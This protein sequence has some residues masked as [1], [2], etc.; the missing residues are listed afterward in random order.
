MS[1]S[2]WYRRFTVSGPDQS[3][4]WLILLVL[5]PLGLLYGVVGRLRV[6]AYRMGWLKSVSLSVPVVSVGNLVAGGTG[7]TPMVDYLLGW[8]RS[9]NIRAAV[10]SRGY[11]GKSES[12]LL[13]VCA[14]DGLLSN[15]ET[16]GDEPCLLAR[17]NPDSIII[18]GSDRG[19]A[20]QEA[21]DHHHAQ[22]LILDDGFQHLRLKRDLNLLLADARRP[23]GN[24]RV[25]PAGYL[26]EFPQAIDRAD[27]LIMTRATGV[28]GMAPPFAG[29]VLKS[30]HR[31]ATTL[32][33]QHGEKIP[34][35]KIRGKKGIAFCGI[36]DPE[37]FFEQIREL[38]VDLVMTY[39]FPDH[40]S[41]PADFTGR[42]SH[43]IGMADFFLTTEKDGVKLGQ[44]TMPL[45][46]YQLS[47]NINFFDGEQVLSTA[48][49]HLINKDKDS[50]P[51]SKDLLEIL[52]CPQ[53]KGE[54]DVNA[55]ESEIVCHHCRL[56]YPVRDEI[57][58]MLIDEA[59]TL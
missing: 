27:I 45:P 22:L 17:R 50:M 24:G 13:T 31:L 14:G 12:A 38:G 21:I 6:F 34:V 3:F 5:L 56:A 15:P 37:A 29:P 10:L 9:H 43:A 4:E 25:L 19:L 47:L 55:D 32:I 46:C 18:V 44:L 39:G 48:L 53:C 30:G 49:E 26:R 52:A 41:Y 35:E 58:V 1:F 23:F 51:L 20:G 28:D 42:F 40:F 57:P 2:G 54:V 59:R 11:G 16:A 7:K 8:C 33:D 36:A